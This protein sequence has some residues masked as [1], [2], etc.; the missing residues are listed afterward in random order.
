MLKLPREL[1]FKDNPNQF[2]MLVILAAAIII[3]LDFYLLL[4]P[5]ISGLTNILSKTA[6]LKSELKGIEADSAKMSKLRE[7]IKGYEAKVDYYEGMLPSEQEIPSLLQNLSDMARSA[8]VKIVSITPLASS[9]EGR[10]DESKI[11]Q[12]FP[13]HITAKSGYH[14]LGMFLS[15]L[16]SANRFM[17]VRDIDIRANKQTPKKHDIDLIVATYILLK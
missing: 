7:A 11:Y 10:A 1:N 12:E 14:E 9:G 4:G 5:Q 6:K 16:E 8:K 17:K 15:S 2:K 3:A 13:I